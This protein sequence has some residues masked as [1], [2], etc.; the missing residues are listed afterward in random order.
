MH[1]LNWLLSVSFLMC[2]VSSMSVDISMPLL[3]LKYSDYAPGNVGSLTG[4]N[5][6]FE[7]I[8]K[9][10]DSLNRN[11][12]ETCLGRWNNQSLQKWYKML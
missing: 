3:L 7:A 9:H 12:M 10:I 4:I 8:I 1:K 2:V 5:T 6:F 11:Q